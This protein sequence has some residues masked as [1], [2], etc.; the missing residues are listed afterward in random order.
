MPLIA[1][2]PALKRQ[3]VAFYGLLV[4]ERN[5]IDT[6]ISSLPSL[7]IEFV[8]AGEAGARVGLRAWDYLDT[9]GGQRFTTVAALH[10]WLKTKTVTDKIPVLVRR[11]SGA[12]PR[13]TADYHRFD[14]QATDLRLLAAGD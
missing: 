11:G 12:D 13:I 5:T 2:E 6:V 1:A 8:K 10:D 3:G 14:I 7:R 9:V 4:T